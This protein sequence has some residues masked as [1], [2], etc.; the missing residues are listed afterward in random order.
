MGKRGIKV[1]DGRT[2]NCMESGEGDNGSRSRP[3]RVVKRVATAME[4]TEL[5]M[6]KWSASAPP[7]VKWLGASHVR[8]HYNWM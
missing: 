5:T 8:I 4:L 1:K 2:I 7:A 3:M 6:L